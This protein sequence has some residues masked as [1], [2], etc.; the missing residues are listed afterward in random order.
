[1]SST[2]IAGKR[3]CR[4]CGHDLES[5]VR[6]DVCQRTK[7]CRSELRLVVRVNA[8]PVFQETIAQRRSGVRGVRVS[9]R[10][11]LTRDAI[12]H[13]QWTVRVDGTPVGQGSANEMDALAEVCR[14]ALVRAAERLRKMSRL[15]EVNRRGDVD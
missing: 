11:R 4:V 12:N 15:L 5:R 9:G 2:T 13:R 3:R 10:V 7:R 1:M 14:H 8:E 6:R